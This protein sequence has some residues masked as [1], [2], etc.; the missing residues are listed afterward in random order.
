M[1]KHPLKHSNSAPDAG[2]FLRRVVEL[3][4]GVVRPVVDEQRAVIVPVGDGA[5][6]R[7]KFTSAL[8]AILV[9]VHPGLGKLAAIDLVGSIDG[10]DASGW[11]LS[12]P[13]LSWPF[14]HAGPVGG[15][16]FL[17]K[18]KLQ[19]DFLNGAVDPGAAMITPVGCD[20]NARSECC[21]V[22]F[23]R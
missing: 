1:K 20:D 7:R 11:I 5:D 12:G 10:E 4:P 18:V 16:S 8:C 9:P 23:S 19:P 22:F 2:N 15:D 6:A 3:E 21:L 14:A 17:I 13:V